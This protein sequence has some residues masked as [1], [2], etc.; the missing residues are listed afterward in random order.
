[1]AVYAVVNGKVY[2]AAVSEETSKY[3]ISWQLDHD[4][5]GSQTFEVMIYDEDGYAAYRKVSVR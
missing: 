3:Q 5:S 2:Q 4:Q 1:M